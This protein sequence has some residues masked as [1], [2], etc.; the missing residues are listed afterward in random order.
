MSRRQSRRRSYGRRQHELSERRDRGGSAGWTVDEIVDD[1]EREPAGG[2]RPPS[3]VDGH[4]RYGRGV[5]P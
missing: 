3:D 1:L 4:A 2:G 5:A